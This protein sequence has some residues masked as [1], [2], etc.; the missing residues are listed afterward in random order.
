[1]NWDLIIDEWTEAL[2]KLLKE[3]GQEIL[4]MNKDEFA[5]WWEMFRRDEWAEEF[6]KYNKDK[7]TQEL[8][9]ILK[10]RNELTKKLNISNHQ[11][12]EAQKDFVKEA[13]NTLLKIGVAAL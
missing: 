2:K 13:L 8:V 7:T 4:K 6:E 9:D 10:L 11:F 5:V 3:K 1:M 12:I